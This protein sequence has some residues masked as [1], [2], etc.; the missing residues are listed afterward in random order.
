ME[1]LSY[2]A[3]D[4]SGT[5]PTL[6]VLLLDMH[7]YGRC[8]N[9]V[10]KYVR[11]IFCILNFACSSLLHAF[12]PCLLQM[13]DIPRLVGGLSFA[14]TSSSSVG[15]SDSATNEDQSTV[16]KTVDVNDLLSSF[17]S[18]SSSLIVD[19]HPPTTSSSSSSSPTMS[20]LQEHDGIKYQVLQSRQQ[21]LVHNLA[22]IEERLATLKSQ[23]NN[24]L[25]KSQTN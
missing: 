2:Q 10:Y 18:T 4:G 5:T 19:T 7:M 6:Q 15:D 22:A 12:L 25:H 14:S 11:L 1:Q 23:P 9:H 16:T 3:P 24:R 21:Q 13:M 20:M 17:S 8:C